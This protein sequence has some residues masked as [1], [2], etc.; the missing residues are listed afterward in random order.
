VQ[1]GGKGFELAH[2]HNVA[3]FR[4]S[5]QVAI[6]TNV[7]AGGIHID[8]P[9]VARQVSNRKLVGFGLGLLCLG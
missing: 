4:N 7:D 3:S 8:V 1:V 5:H 2:R 9:Q 6:R